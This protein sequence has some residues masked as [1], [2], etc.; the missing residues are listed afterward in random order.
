MITPE[1]YAQLAARTP[2]VSAPKPSRAAG[3]AEQEPPKKKKWF[4]F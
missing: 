3:V 1:A 4:L 2:G